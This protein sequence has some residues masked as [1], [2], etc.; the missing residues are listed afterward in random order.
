M[1][2]ML[3]HGLRLSFPIYT[4]SYFL[5]EMYDL[6][7]LCALWPSL[8][9]HFLGFYSP[10]SFVRSKPPL[11]NESY[12][13]FQIQNV[14]KWIIYHQ[15]DCNVG[16]PLAKRDSILGRILNVANLEYMRV[17]NLLHLSTSPKLTWFP[18]LSFCS[19]LFPK[20]TLICIDLQ[21]D[22][23]ANLRSV[24]DKEEFN[25]V[26]NIMIPIENPQ[27]SQNIAD[28][29]NHKSQE[30]SIRHRSLRS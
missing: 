20:R 10:T 25:V 4:L 15:T 26:A 13:L 19:S 1:T 14:C 21:T 28:I 11:M 22:S 9:F 30:P 27:S 18:F 6:S 3:Q 2:M 24:S 16:L 23:Q 7:L 17:T 5:K 12:V 29:Q 8:Y